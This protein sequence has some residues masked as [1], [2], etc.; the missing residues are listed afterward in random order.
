MGFRSSVLGGNRVKDQTLGQRIFLVLIL[1]RILQEFKSSVPR[2]GGPS[3][4]IFSIILQCPIAP[5]KKLFH[6][7]TDSPS[8]FITAQSVDFQMEAS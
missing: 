5:C 2:P 6:F 7:V 1:L 4:Y 8:L 3:Q